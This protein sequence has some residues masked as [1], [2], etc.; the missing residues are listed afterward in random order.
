MR[1]RS[2]FDGLYAGSGPGLSWR[3]RSVPAV[4]HVVDFPED[5]DPE[6][7]RV[8]RPTFS[9]RPP[10]AYRL[11]EPGDTIDRIAIYLSA[12]AVV[13]SL[14]GLGLG[15]GPA[16]LWPSALAIALAAFWYAATPGPT[17]DGWHGL[18]WRA[19]ADP[20]AP[21]PLRIVLVGAALG[22]SGIVTATVVATRSRW[23]ELADHGRAEGMRSLLVA[24]LV[25]VACARSRSRASSRPATGRAGPGLGADRLRPGAGARHARR[26]VSST[27]CVALGSGSWVRRAGWRWSPQGSG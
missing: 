25:L 1:P 16:G 17:F 19:I 20:E 13:I 11:A 27:G 14:A 2:R 6:F 8:V 12:G 4:W 26:S 9:R 7:P 18:G 15:R 24:A 21:L 22:L 23:G 10:P 3:W 5:I